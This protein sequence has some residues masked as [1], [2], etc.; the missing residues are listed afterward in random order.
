MSMTDPVADLL[1][2]VRNGIRA[3]KSHVDVSPTSRLREAVLGALKR[4]GYIE[5]FKRVE[6]AAAASGKRK[7]RGAASFPMVR[8]WLKYD[9]DRASVVSKI[10]RVSKPGCR[11]F[12][13][14]EAVKGRKILDGLG[15]TVLSTSRGVLS[16]REARKQNVGGEVLCEVW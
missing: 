16:D 3:K 9:V 13:G 10:R 2:R 1:T 4:E 8:V 14:I 6:P 5:D 11:V 7:I 12:R 15:I